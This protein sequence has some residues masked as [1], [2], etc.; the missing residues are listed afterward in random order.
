M[1]T[2]LCLYTYPT[3]LQIIAIDLKRGMDTSFL[4]A[5]PHLCGRV[6]TTADEARK[7]LAW[8]VMK[9]NERLDAMDAAGVS[10][11]NVL[12]FW[13]PGVWPRYVVV[14]DELAELTTIE[15]GDDKAARAE[16]RAAVAHLQTIARLGRAAGFHLVLSTQRPDADV[17]P[18]QLKANLSTTIAFRVRS[19]LNSRIIFDGDEAANLP[20]IPGRGLLIHDDVEEFQ[21]PF[22]SNERATQLLRDRWFEREATDSVT[23]WL[24]SPER[25]AA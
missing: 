16:Q 20:P 11:V 23:P 25:D 24:Q 7:A 14:C 2:R 6:V 17:V 8:I 5:A 3:D 10:D 1:L 21:G 19:K 9:L 22:L 18:G 4:A 12:Q 13:A 15:H